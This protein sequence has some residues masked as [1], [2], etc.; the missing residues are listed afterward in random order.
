MAR[1][2]EIR[3]DYEPE[4]RQS[5]K[6]SELQKAYKEGCIH[7]YEKAMKEL[8]E[9]EYRRGGSYIKYRDHDDEDDYRGGRMR[10]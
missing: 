4:Y 10:R 7:G 2:W 1:L 8:D 9:M 6:H 5:G 3:E